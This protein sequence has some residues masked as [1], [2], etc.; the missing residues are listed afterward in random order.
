MTTHRLVTK[1]H[2]ARFLGVTAE[3]IDRFVQQDRLPAFEFDGQTAFDEQHLS[4][5][6][7]ALDLFR[8]KAPPGTSSHLPEADPLLEEVRRFLD[9]E[10]IRHDRKAEIPARTLFELY[11][12][13][14]NEHGIEPSNQTRFGIAMRQTGVRREQRA[15]GRWYVGITDA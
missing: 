15:N 13:W 4:H 3:M 1:E 6:L 7:Q 12:E 5:F 2:A 10:R 8:S 9:S 14:A 11:C